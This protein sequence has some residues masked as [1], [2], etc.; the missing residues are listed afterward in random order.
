MISVDHNSQS[1]R[2]RY[3][4]STLQRL[5]KK[6]EQLELMVP[7]FPQVS[8]YFGDVLIFESVP[9]DNLATSIK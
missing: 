3:S 9:Y 8:L 2:M 6:G 4:P 1:V 5:A 7:L